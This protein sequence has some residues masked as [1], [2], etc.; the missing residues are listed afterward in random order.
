MTTEK[1][2]TLMRRDRVALVSLNRPAR[3]NALVP[4]LLSELLQAL[5]HED[6]RDAAA[7]VLRAEG[8]SFS[9]GG[10]LAGFRDHRET[11][12]A[13]ADGLVGQLNEV[14]LAIYMH[15]APMV[16]AVQGQVT[17]GSLGLL[18]AADHVIMRRGATITPYYSLV[19]FS[20]DGGWTALLP[21]I[22]GRQQ[23]MHW[24]A[25]NASHDADTCLALGLVHRVIEDD[26]DAAALEWARRVA[27]KDPGSLRRTRR[28]L[29]TEG[30][31]LRQRLQAERDNFVSQIQTQTA[32]DGIDL[33]LRRKEHV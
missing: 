14:I 8:R 19:G 28:L 23:S 13:Y 20:P 1:P 18:L 30:E 4:E 29:N 17:G 24:L 33:F 9:T 2:V 31:A 10:D 26:C 12:A 15:P 6:C 25:S 21:G 7:V 3:H 5:E 27:E 11:I 16:C 32:V 22:I